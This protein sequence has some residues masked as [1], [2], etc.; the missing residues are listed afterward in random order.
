M[1]PHK[2][3]FT[4]G[5][6]AAVTAMELALERFGGVFAA[7]EKPVGHGRSIWA[8]D[9]YLD[10]APPYDAV[11]EAIIEGALSVS[12]PAPDFHLTP[13][14]Q[15]DWV[16]ENQ[17]SFQPIRAG[18]FYL[19]PSHDTRPP[20]A[21]SWSL[22][23]DAGVAFGTGEHGTTKG[24]L[25]EI[26]RLSRFMSPGRILDLGCGT[27]VLSMGSAR[28]WRAAQIIGSDIDPDA[29]MVSHEN[30]QR[31]QL[32]PAQQKG[33]LR[34][35]HADGLAD[36]ALAATAPYD[37]IIANILANP[38]RHLAKQIQGASTRNGWLILSGLREEQQSL[39]LEAYRRHGYRLD[40]RRILDGW[41]ILTLRRGGR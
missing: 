12:I 14:P 5:S 1:G 13:L 16:A 10:G 30:A 3:S 35:V 2:L 40:H 23:L 33:A 34:Y 18:R 25:L 36:P 17:K 4:V 19:Y 22:E 29:V 26:D 24:C 8:V 6:E 38:L 27:G 20:P 41:A 21:G 7:F 15:I 9:L 39:V 28:V 32:G 37:L 11:T 31:N